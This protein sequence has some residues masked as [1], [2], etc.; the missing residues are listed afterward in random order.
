MM[1][2]GTAGGAG[3]SAPLDGTGTAS[4][5]PAEAAMTADMAGAGWPAPEAMTAGAST[6]L[7]AA[8]AA[9]MAGTGWPAPPEAKGAGPRYAADELFLSLREAIL[10]GMLKP[11]EKLTEQRLCDDFHVSRTPVR[12]ALKQLGI[13][14]LVETAPNRGATV[15]GFSKRDIEDMFEMRAAYEIHAARWA[16]GRMSPA[17]LEML[18]ETFEFMEFYT[19]KGAV[20]KTIDLNSKFHQII[21]DAS[22]NRI[23]QKILTSYQ[24]YI[25]QSVKTRQYLV[26]ELP[27]LLEEHRAIF[28]AIR[29]GDAAAAEASMREHMDS[30]RRRALGR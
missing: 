11:G 6:M 16:A 15:I 17:Q 22:Q 26:E 9:G 13:E 18:E 20:G 14:G 30:L 2:P 28:T 29:A 5:A 7:D 24:T 12:E 27:L 25:K 4:P 10:K 1:D 8:R 21:Y 3:A 23:M 19:A